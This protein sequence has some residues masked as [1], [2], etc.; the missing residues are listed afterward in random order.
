MTYPIH[1]R[2]SKLITSKSINALQTA[3]EIGEGIQEADADVK[4]GFCHC[5]ITIITPE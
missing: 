4:S 3:V 1:P 2:Y 5:T